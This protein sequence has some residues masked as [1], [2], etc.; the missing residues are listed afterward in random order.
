[1]SILPL[2]PSFKAK[3]CSR[4]HEIL[5]LK[6]FE[7]LMGNLNLKYA[8]KAVRDAAILTIA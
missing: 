3:V 1:M 2:K 7:T 6:L 4:N 5:T 8:R